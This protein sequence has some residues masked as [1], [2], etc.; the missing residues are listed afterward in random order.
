CVEAERVVGAAE[1]V[2]NGFGHTDDGESQVGHGLRRREGPLTAD[3]DE[4]SDTGLVEDFSD[5]FDTAVIERVGAARADDGAAEFADAPDIESSQRRIVLI[6]DAPPAILKPDEFESVHL[7]AGEYD[8]PD[9]R[10]EA[11]RVA[12][13]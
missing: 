2:V 3:D 4:G 11:G 7:H 5:S 9:D 12:P 6:Q 1:V 13:A 10:V 8:A